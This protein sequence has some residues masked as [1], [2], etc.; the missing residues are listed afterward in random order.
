M[1]LKGTQKIACISRISCISARLLYF[2]SS[3]RPR[4]LIVISYLLLDFDAFWV[5]L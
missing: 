1:K 4:V 5:L 3:A 2:P